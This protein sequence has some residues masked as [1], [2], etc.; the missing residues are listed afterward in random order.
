MSSQKVLPV[1]SALSGAD[2][3]VRSF[4]NGTEEPVSSRSERDEITPLRQDL[5]QD[6]VPAHDDKFLGGAPVKSGNAWAH[7]KS[8]VILK[9]T[10]SMQALMSA[11]G[12]PMLREKQ[13]VVMDRVQ[14]ASK[15][16]SF[17]DR[18]SYKL[19]T[20]ISTKKG[21]IIALCL[22]GLIMI[23]SGGSTLKAAE[24]TTVW[25]DS[26]WESWTFLADPGSHTSQTEAV[27]SRPLVELI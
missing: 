12:K 23:T 3:V 8:T 27:R 14:N 20:Y 11:T 18:I 10:S 22:F 1:D 4:A 6:I 9:K 25:A 15:H 26:I 17:L 2:T 24:P 5:Q 13:K 16:H 19:D 21:Q 7:T